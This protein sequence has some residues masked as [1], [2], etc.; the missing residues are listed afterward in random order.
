[1]RERP[2]TS[3][4]SMTCCAYS[5][6]RIRTMVWM[7]GLICLA[8]TQQSRLTSSALVTAISKSASAVPT[9]RR[10]SMVAQFPSI[11]MTSYLAQTRSTTSA[12]WSTMVISCPSEASCAVRVEPTFPIPAMIIFML[13]PRCVS[14]GNASKQAYIRREIIAGFRE[15]YKQ[16]CRRSR[17]ERGSFSKFFCFGAVFQSG[18]S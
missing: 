5:E 15:K 4:I 8:V 9:S 6:L 11:P 2:K 17:Q 10:V 7:P 14:V 16:S 3:R 1:M 13:F 18:R 12:L